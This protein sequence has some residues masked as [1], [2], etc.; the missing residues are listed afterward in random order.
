MAKG[1][2]GAAVIT[3]RGRPSDAK[4]RHGAVITR[5]GH[6]SDA[7]GRYG[8]VIAA[9]RGEWAQPGVGHHAAWATHLT[10]VAAMGADMAAVRGE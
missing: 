1:Q 6:P 7:S 5:R 4:G 8:A 3:R 10:Q 2:S 9:I